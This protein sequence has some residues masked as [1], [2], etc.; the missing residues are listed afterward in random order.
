MSYEQDVKEFE[1]STLGWAWFDEPPPLPIFKATVARMRRGG[2]IFITATPLAGSSWMYDHII[3][4][5]GD[6]HGQRD[7]IHATVEANCQT[8]GVRGILRHEDIMRMV[9]EYDE[10]DK[11]ARVYGKFQHL[12]GMVFKQFNRRVH[13]IKP[14]HISRRDFL[15]WEAI[16]PHPR[17]PDAVLWVAVDTKGRKFV[18]DE[19]YTADYFNGAWKPY[20]LTNA[21]LVQRIRAKSEGFRIEERI[22]DP[23]MFN[24]D[25]HQDDPAGMTLA[26]KLSELGLDYAPATKDRSTADKVVGDAL[27]FE[28]VGDEIV[29]APELYVFDTCVRTIWEIEHYQWE[30]WRGKAAERKSPKER[31]MDKDDHEIEC[32]GRILVR[33]PPSVRCP[34]RAMLTA[35]A[36]RGSSRRTSRSIRPQGNNGT[37]P[38]F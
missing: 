23:S 36:P 35:T 7:Y 33:Q 11:Q 20:R 10:D 5:R 34:R 19:L 1:S 31:P 30:D 25:K 17:N 4:H 26:A 18:V 29:R 21:A 24:Q 2:V 37:P 38:A 22:G 27:N 8:H 3:T 28:K 13:V 14:F 9:G 16:D 6:D 12:T 32:L 15:V